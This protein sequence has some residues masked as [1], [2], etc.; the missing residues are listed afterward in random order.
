MFYM[1]DHGILQCQETNQRKGS[2]DRLIVGV[3]GTEQLH[4]WDGQ[5]DLANIFLNDY[6]IA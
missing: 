3:V 5:D 2:R 4:C 6:P 1:L